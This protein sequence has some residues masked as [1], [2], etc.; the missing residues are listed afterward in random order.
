MRKILLNLFALLLIPHGVAFGQAPSSSSPTPPAKPD[1]TLTE[2]Q[3]ARLDALRQQVFRWQDKMQAA[4]EQFSAV[5]VEAQKE[6]KWAPV[7]C[8][9]ADLSVAPQTPPTPPQIIASPAA[10][11]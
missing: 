9:L 4:L 1:L 6:N 5:C 10:K 2:L 11:K 8:S 3:K 7:T